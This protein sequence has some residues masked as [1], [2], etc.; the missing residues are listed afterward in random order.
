MLIMDSMAIISINHL[1]KRY[2]GVAAI[3]DVSFSVAKG[4]VIGFVG[5]NGAGKSTTI[6]LMM[7]FLKAS[8][9]TVRIFDRI[10]TPQTAHD[11]HQQ[12]GFASGDMS[13]F[14]NLTGRQYFKFLTNEYKLT[15][16][17]RL[18]ELMQRFTPQLDKKISDL[19]RGNK[20]KIA[21]IGAFMAS[22]KLVIL[23]EPSSGLDPLMQ[24][25]F[26]DLVREEAERGTTI[27]MSSHYLNEVADVCTR[28]LLMRNGELVKDIPE[29]QLAA[30][31]GKIVTI[32]SKRLAIPPKIAQAVVER[33]TADGYELSFV[34]KGQSIHLQHWLTSVPQLTDFTVADHDLESAF[35]DIYA[36]PADKGRHV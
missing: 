13:L 9:G 12:I 16:Q 11:T 17:K 28:V 7:G 35:S 24:Q 5:L 26:L 3:S 34:F 10:V 1:T 30:A 14:S 19:S 32:L 6:N 22:P 18:E 2:Q 4:E 27:F 21:L 31:S 29:Q 36:S 23:D 8:A 25:A 33:K 20:Q 15:S